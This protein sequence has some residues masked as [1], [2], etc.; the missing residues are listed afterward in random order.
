MTSKTEKLSTIILEHSSGMDV[1][2]I[3]KA[4]VIALDELAL[5]ESTKT[6]DIASVCAGL[7]DNELADYYIKRQS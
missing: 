7:L 5:T 3:V 1:L 2:E 6:A 4:M